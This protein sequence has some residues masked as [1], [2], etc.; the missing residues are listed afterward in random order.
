[1]DHPGLTSLQQVLV[2]L[3]YLMKT[4]QLSPGPLLKLRIAEQ[5]S[6]ALQQEY[7]QVAYGV[8]LLQMDQMVSWVLAQ[9]QTQLV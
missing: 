7:L 8:L 4:V 9:V 1:M 2:A 3:H 5:L 6:K